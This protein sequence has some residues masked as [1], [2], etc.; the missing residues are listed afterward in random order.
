MAPTL[1]MA[2]IVFMCA[3]AEGRHYDFAAANRLRR[4]CAKLVFFTMCTFRVASALPCSELIWAART[5]LLLRMLLVKNGRC[6]VK[7]FAAR[8]MTEGPH[9]ERRWKDKDTSRGAMAP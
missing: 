3:S 2:M 4:V 6:L 1:A 7:D 9:V 8:A 5:S